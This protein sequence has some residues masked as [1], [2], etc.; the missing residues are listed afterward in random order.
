MIIPGDAPTPRPEIIN[1][2]VTFNELN[3]ETTSD[4]SGCGVE[5]FI[6]D[7]RLR[8]NSVNAFSLSG[9]VVKVL[10]LTNGNLL[11]NAGFRISEEIV[12]HD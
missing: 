9:L 11:E 1:D 5:K 4:T 2:L 3:H 6:L 12:T 8:N 7:A 10:E